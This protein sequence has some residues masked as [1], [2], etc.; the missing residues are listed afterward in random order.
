M[1]T[2]LCLLLRGHVHVEQKREEAPAEEEAEV[3]E[4]QDDR[5][6]DKLRPTATGCLLMM[7]ADGQGSDKLLL[8]TLQR[9]ADSEPSVSTERTSNMQKNIPPG[10]KTDRQADRQSNNF[11]IQS[12]IACTNIQTV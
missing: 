7:L 1:T 6:L 10:R 8:L 11:K 3:A 4:E 12:S 2:T 9:S 5:K